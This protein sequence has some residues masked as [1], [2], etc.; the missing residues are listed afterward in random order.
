MKDNLTDIF[1]NAIERKILTGEWNIGDRLP[2]LRELS[3]SMG[4][5]R[6]VVNAGIAQLDKSGYLKIVPRKYI[7]VAD[8]KK[9]GTLNVLNALL[10]EE[11]LTDEVLNSVLSARRL[12][13]IECVRLA[14]LNANEEDLSLLLKHIELEA[15]EKSIEKRVENDI[16]FHQLICILSKNAVYPLVIKSFEEISK[17]LVTLFYQQDSVFETVVKIHLEIYSAIKGKN[18]E[19]AVSSME[20]L[21]LHGEIE[22]HNTL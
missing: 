3:E 20:L 12:L 10:R 1:V 16:H 5:S 22:I 7:E 19:R 6:S 8:W 17:K 4:V 11:L 9:E 14:C 13:E 21:L 2:T 18:V 15:Q